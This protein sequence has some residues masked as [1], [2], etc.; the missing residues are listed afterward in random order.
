MVK[1]DTMML[2]SLIPKAFEGFEMIYN[3]I[4]DN[5]IRNKNM[6]VETVKVNIWE[7]KP[8]SHSP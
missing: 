3:K 1:S 4:S 7:M 2:I 5:K 6:N 8:Q